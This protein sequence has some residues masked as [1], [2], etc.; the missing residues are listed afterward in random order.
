MSWASIANNQ[1]VSLANLQNAVNNGVF[2]LKNTIPVS[3]KQTT[4]G[5]AEYYVNLIPTGKAATQLVVK[6]NLVSPPTT[7]TTSSTSTTTTTTTFSPEP[8]N[9]VEVNITSAG[10]EVATF[11]CFGQNQNYVYMNAGTYYICAAVVGGL[12][13][14]DIIAGTGTLTPIGNCK[15]GPCGGTTTTTTTIFTPIYVPVGTS[16]PFTTVAVS[17]GT[18]QYQV[19]GNSNF[20]SNPWLQGFVFVSDDYGVNW[21]KTAL[22]GYWQKVA[23]SDDGR[24]MLAVEYY[25]KAYRSS[26]YGQTWTQITNFPFPAPFNPGGFLPLQTLNFRGA[27]LSDNGQ[28]Q[29]ICTAEDFYGNDTFGFQYFFNTIFVSNDYGATWAARS[30]ETNQDGVYNAVAISANGQTVLAARGRSVIGVG[31]VVRST[32]YGV[33]W[34][35]LSSTEAAGN[36]VDIA[37]LADGSRAI[38]ARFSNDYFPYLLASTNGGA[39]WSNITGGG[40]AAQQ[41][42]TDVA[43]NTIGPSGASA[44]AVSLTNSVNKFIQQVPS[45][46][47]VN[48]LTSSG[49]RRWRS[50]ANSN[51]SQYVLGATTAGL[52]KSSNSGTSWSQVP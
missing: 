11:N 17:R 30:V 13:Q 36:L 42:W 1:C 9:C 4:T 23:T 35:V 21:Y 41:Q 51:D 44:L 18:G 19:A 33:N 32:N 29:V 50:L 48:Q 14:A 5:E 38:A 8:C 43:I 39:T 2:T 28:Y 15:T 24:Y 16:T 40:L 10:G 46:T 52:F 26:N 6:S 34:S 25:G 45:L 37:I 31:T 7:T 20:N 49:S 3:N 27:A 22:F 47:S 12:L